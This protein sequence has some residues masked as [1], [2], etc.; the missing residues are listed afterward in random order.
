MFNCWIYSVSQLYILFSP[1]LCYISFL[2]R[3]LYILGDDTLV[4]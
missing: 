3:D 1:Y 2:Y 4:S